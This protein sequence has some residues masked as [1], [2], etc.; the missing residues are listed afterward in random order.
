MSYGEDLVKRVNAYM[1][2][3]EVGRF[4]PL[5]ELGG[6]LDVSPTFVQRVIL[7]ERTHELAFGIARGS[8]RHALGLVRVTE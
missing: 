2:E 4:V 1:A 7:F 6:A 5:N 8:L 3:V